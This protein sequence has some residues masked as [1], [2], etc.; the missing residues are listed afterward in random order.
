MG[1]KDYGQQEEIDSIVVASLGAP[2]LFMCRHSPLQARR[3]L[4]RLYG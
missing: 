1:R 3:G 4:P 2:W